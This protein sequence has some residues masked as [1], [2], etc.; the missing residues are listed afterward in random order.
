MG[1]KTT[2][3]KLNL[4]RTELKSR[5]ARIMIIGLGSVG[6]YL[7]DYLMSN[8]DENI[9]LCVVGRNEQKMQSDV[10]IVK[11]ASMIRGQNRSNIKI[12][13][14]VDLTDIFAIQ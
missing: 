9:E 10:N 7:L 11:V 4:M 5:K 8:A 1:M 6:N 12:I 2:N 14:N 13:G 3:E